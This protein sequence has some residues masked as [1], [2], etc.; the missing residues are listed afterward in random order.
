MLNGNRQVYRDDMPL[1]QI[2]SQ[3]FTVYIYL[4]IL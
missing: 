4:E 1:T 3:N 2:K